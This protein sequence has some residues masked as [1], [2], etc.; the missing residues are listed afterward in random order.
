VPNEDWRVCET[1]FLGGAPA[2]FAGDQFKGIEHRPND[3]RLDNA[4]LPD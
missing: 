1:D 4:A 2:A 3:K